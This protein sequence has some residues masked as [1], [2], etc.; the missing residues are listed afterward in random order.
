MMDYYG[1]N[2]KENNLRPRA[3]VHPEAEHYRGKAVG[4][5]LISLFWFSPHSADGVGR[6]SQK[7]GKC[8]RL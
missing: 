3:G 4:E 7:P 2:T 6:K 1:N 5:A 8:Y